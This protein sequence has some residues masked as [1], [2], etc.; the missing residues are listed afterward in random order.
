M[1]GTLKRRARVAR[2]K[3]LSRTC[4][5]CGCQPYR[6][7]SKC[8]DYM[9]CDF[10]WLKVLGLKSSDIA[11]LQCVEIRLGRSIE[12]DDLTDAICNRTLRN[13]IRSDLK[14]GALYPSR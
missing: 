11:C 7:D 10:I 14:L 13:M 4:A 3:F 12:L 5:I 2:E 9:L 8:V 1:M 6:D